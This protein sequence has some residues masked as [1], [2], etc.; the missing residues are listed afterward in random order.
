MLFPD[1]HEDPVD[2]GKA[3]K[4]KAREAEPGAAESL[5]GPI[6]TPELTAPPK[7]L[8]RTEDMHE[9]LDERCL[10]GYHEILDEHA[11]FW[12]LSCMFCGTMQRV[13]AI[14]GY[15]KPQQ[16]SF[17]FPSG[18]YAGMGISD[19][20]ADQRGRAYIEWAAGDHK[21]QIIKDACRTHLDTI[22]PA[23]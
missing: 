9:C 21:N 13:R 1:M 8:G 12:L 2:A 15:L 14:R 6:F 22:R 3:K 7:P 10:G 17:V 11:G 4:R 19:V 5:H 16:A 23:S 18:D 20:Y